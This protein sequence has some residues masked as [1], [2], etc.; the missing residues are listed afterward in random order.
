MQVKSVNYNQITNYS[1]FFATSKYNLTIFVSIL[2]SSKIRTGKSLGASSNIYILEYLKNLLN[3][4]LGSQSM[5]EYQE[6][7]IVN[8]ELDKIA[9]LCFSSFIELN[10]NI[11]LILFE[12]I[13]NESYRKNYVAIKKFNLLKI[14]NFQ[15]DDVSPIAISTTSINNVSM[16]LT[17]NQAVLKNYTYILTLTLI[18]NFSTNLLNQSSLEFI[19]LENNILNI[20]RKQFLFFF[21]FFTGVS[22][23]GVKKKPACFN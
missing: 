12:L 9:I 2:E 14:N 6:L 4:S 18:A 10:K 22:L 16:A 5:K 7:V 11:D 8:S 17:Q 15:K 1:N 19:D 3:T 21:I 13:S 20:V 23:S